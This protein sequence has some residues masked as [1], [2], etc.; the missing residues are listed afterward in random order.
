MVK[1]FRTPPLDQSCG[2]AGTSSHSYNLPRRGNLRIS[3]EMTE[4]NDFPVNPKIQRKLKNVGL[5]V[6]MKTNTSHSNCQQVWSLRGC[7]K[8][9]LH[10]NCLDLVQ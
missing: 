6:W 4:K 8:F 2:L 3:E 1:N 10:I 9:Q 5:I 7:Y